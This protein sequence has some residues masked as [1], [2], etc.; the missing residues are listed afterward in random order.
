MSNSRYMGP[1]VRETM[2]ARREAA[3]DAYDILSRSPEDIVNEIISDLGL[4]ERYRLGPDGRVGTDYRLTTPE[5]RARA[6]ERIQSELIGRYK[7]EVERVEEP[8]TQRQPQTKRKPK[9]KVRFDRIA[10]VSVVA[11]ILVSL[12]FAISKGIISGVRISQDIDGKTKD[13][14]S[15]SETVIPGNGS[16]SQ[17][18]SEIAPD[19]G[20]SDSTYE[21]PDLKT[22]EI[23]YVIDFMDYY[24]PSQR[25]NI[26]QMLDQG[27]ID[28]LGIRIGG[29]E[30]DYPFTIK[31]FTD[32]EINAPLQRYVDNGQLELDHDYGLEL[33]SA[34]EY[35]LKAP[36]TIP[37]YLTCC[38]NREEAA[39]E[40]DCIE[41][42]YNLMYKDMQGYDF[43]DRMAPIAID[44]EDCG[45]IKLA[46]NED[47]LS[48][49]GAMSQRADAVLYLIDT[50]R[51][52]GII[53]ERGV[54]IYGDLNRMKDKSQID[55][56]GLFQGLQ[57]RN[58][59]VVKWG[60]RAINAT[61][62]DPNYPEDTV[63]YENI[64]A[65]RDALMNTATNISY[66]KT[67]Y[68]KS[69]DS[70]VP[71]LTDVAIQQIHLDQR[72]ETDT[73]GEKYDINIT[74]QNTLDAIVHGNHIDYSKGFID[75]IEDTRIQ[76][77]K[78]DLTVG[79]TQVGN[80]VPSEYRYSQLSR[81]DDGDR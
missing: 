57:E 29:S 6:S 31:D 73:Y 68:D 4:D 38:I 27:M 3:E 41:A 47:Y 45:E 60:T 24:N 20:G 40:A 46:Q 8:E 66:M 78:S 50:L 23:S 75:R 77:V 10:A 19:I 71:Y 18:S 51:E 67:E 15:E 34:E 49:I 35:I 30:E 37:Y 2:D 62:N 25:E 14:L 43:K 64:Y 22:D 1:K 12:G 32:E 53:D 26:N 33:A 13:D 5:E 65:F 76:E 72:M 63:E 28:G 74:T 58:I 69:G 9:R 7:R 81:D 56:K 61:Y 44:I 48:R 52:K 54:I 59:N 70:L 42:T 55:W 21:V 16:S 11:T 39:I 79:D 17:D 36:V 80:Y